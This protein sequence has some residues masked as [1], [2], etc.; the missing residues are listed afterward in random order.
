MSKNIYEIL[1]TYLEQGNH[2]DSI[3]WREFLNLEIF[4]GSDKYW[5]YHICSTVISKPPSKLYFGFKVVTIFARQPRDSLLTATR[6][7]SSV[8]VFGSSCV[9][10]SILVCWLEKMCLG[11]K[12]F[13]LDSLLTASWQPGVF[14]LCCFGTKYLGIWA[15]YFDVVN[16]LKL[17]LFGPWPTIHHTKAL[18]PGFTNS[19][20]TG[21]TAPKPIHMH[22]TLPLFKSANLRPKVW[23]VAAKANC[24][25]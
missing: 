7:R 6:K 22:D 3:V 15:I 18:D 17:S 20:L 19:A 24:D 1:I 13:S 21:T 9:N 14:T 8:F 12:Y 10:V 5:C 25:S 23:A 16:M 2:K 11:K 4:W